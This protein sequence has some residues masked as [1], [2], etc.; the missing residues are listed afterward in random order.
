MSRLIRVG[1]IVTKSGIVLI[2]HAQP[3]LDASKPARDWVLGSQGEEQ[4]RRLGALLRPF[5][6][7]RLVTSPEPKALQTCE[8]VA[9]ELDIP[10]TVVDGL[11]E[12]ERPVLPIMSPSEHERVNAR[13]FSEFDH[14]AI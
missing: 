11:Q 6:P 8:I 4:S 3:L 14:R 7:G 9:D 10:M 5:L 12:I 2:K 1:G 13:I